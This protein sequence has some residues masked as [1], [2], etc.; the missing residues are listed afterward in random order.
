MEVLK[1]IDCSENIGVSENIINIAIGDWIRDRD[2]W[3]A[4]VNRN[5]PLGSIKT[6]EFVK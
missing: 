6:G 4:V 3:R 1:G 2:K 5:K